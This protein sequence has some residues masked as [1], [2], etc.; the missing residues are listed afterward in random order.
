MK[1]RS[2]TSTLLFGG[3]LAASLGSDLTHGGLYVSKAHARGPG[4][5]AGTGSSAGRGG[6]AGGRGGAAE[7]AASA[8]RGDGGGAPSGAAEG[9]ASAGRGD[10][11]A[12]QGRAGESTASADRSNARDSKDGVGR[13]SRDP[14]DRGMER[15]TRH[16]QA[17]ATA[18]DRY[19]RALGV[20]SHL[21]VEVSAQPGQG[22]V[23]KTAV[24]ITSEDAEP[25]VL[26]DDEATEALI[27]RGWDTP[28]ADF[29]RAFRER[30]QGEGETP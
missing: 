5:E 2:V 28:P 3:M 7:G 19:N 18:R 14:S 23:S 11:S 4:G 8:G 1:W 25:V 6:D 9:T 24:V 21:S 13:K 15:A 12:D 30:M 27:E 29:G 22:L 20:T 16:E 17:L 26:F 10:G